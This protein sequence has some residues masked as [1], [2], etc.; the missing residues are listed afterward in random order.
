MLPRRPGAEPFK[1]STQNDSI[2]PAGLWL[3]GLRALGRLWGLREPA[4][5]LLSSGDGAA[6]T[7]G[8]PWAGPTCLS[9][10]GCGLAGRGHRAGFLGGG[11]GGNMRLGLFLLIWD[12][13]YFLIGLGVN[14]WV[15]SPRSER[16]G[17]W[18]VHLEGRL[19]PGAQ[20][21]LE[22]ALPGVALGCAG[23]DRAGG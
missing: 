17:H 11:A 22:A 7:G 4:A 13:A 15:R 3:R 1:G 8:P 19:V 20:G 12:P 18:S 9:S 2:K 5:H 16:A 14:E 23:R 6:P 10:P 21:G